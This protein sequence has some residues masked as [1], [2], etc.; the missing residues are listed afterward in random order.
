MDF[1]NIKDEKMT[2]YDQVYDF[3]VKFMYSEKATKFCK[4]FPLLLTVCKER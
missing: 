2:H 3:L 1:D 4:I